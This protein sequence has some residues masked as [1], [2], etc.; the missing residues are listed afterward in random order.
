MEANAI[1]LSGK[2]FTSREDN[3]LGLA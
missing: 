2:F 1:Q 3:G